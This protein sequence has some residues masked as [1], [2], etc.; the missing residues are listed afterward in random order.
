[1]NAPRSIDD[2]LRQLRTALEGQDPA[3]IQDALYDAEEYL[4]AEVAAHPD[5]SEGDVLELIASTY[6]APDEVAAAY[7]DTEAKV[8]A[9]LRTPP[10]RSA[11][12]DSA[13][14][15][16]FSIYRDPR[17]YTSLFYMVLALAT[18]IVYFTIVVTGLSLSAGLAVLIIGV[19]FFLAFIGITRVIALAEGR[20]LEA[21]SGERMPR[22]PVHPGPPQSWWARIG[23]MLTDV[24]TWTTLGYLLLMLPIGIIYF[25]VAV[26]LVAVSTS[27]IAAPVLVLG[28]QLG[29]FTFTRNDDLTIGFGFFPHHP[30][31]GA[32][33][34]CV[35]GVAL[36]TAF[37]HAA[38]AL[39]R[40]HAYLAKSLLVVPGS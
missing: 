36:L 20:L 11:S 12:S 14:K 15:R 26:T 4:R 9:A 35:L 6:G 30:M 39:L 40:G 16:F 34:L 33:V 7:R 27:F 25:T 23:A 1:M 2:Y 24:R 10:P 13:W 32:L 38:R 18:G 22:R 21:I 37:L 19:P 28:D 5:K 8:K 17:A 3:L 29:W 31:I